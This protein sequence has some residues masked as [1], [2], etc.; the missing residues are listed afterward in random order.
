MLEEKQVEKSE[1]E[2]RVNTI[3][4]QVKGVKLDLTIDEAKELASC[5][6]ELFMVSAGKEIDKEYIPLPYPVYPYYP[7]YWKVKYDTNRITYGTPIDLD[8]TKINTVTFTL[9]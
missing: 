7:Q 8:S 2:I 1:K 6:N 4:L 5:L 9:L 3:E